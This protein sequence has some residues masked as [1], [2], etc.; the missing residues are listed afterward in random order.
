MGN[1][2]NNPEYNIEQ[3]QPGKG[4]ANQGLLATGNITEQTPAAACVMLSEG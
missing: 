4:S 1:E 2:R 3:N